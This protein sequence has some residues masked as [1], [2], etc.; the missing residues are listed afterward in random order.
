MKLKPSERA[1]K[2]IQKLSKD[3]KVRKRI[4]EFLIFCKE[5]EEDVIKGRMKPCRSPLHP[6]YHKHL[7]KELLIFATFDGDTCIIN[8]LGHWEQF[9]GK[10]KYY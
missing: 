6:A 5:N 4:A 8:D 10:K 7:S 1:T 2:K 3:N 9:F